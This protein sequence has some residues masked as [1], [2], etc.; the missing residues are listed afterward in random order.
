M[1]QDVEQSI[2]D[3]VW[4]DLVED[5][6]SHEEVRTWLTTPACGAVVCFAGVVRDHSMGHSGVTSI[7]Y[8]SY[9]QAVMPR[10]ARIVERAIVA[11]P[12]TERAAIVHRTGLVALGEGAVVVG[13]SAPH[14]GTAFDVARFCID[15]VKETLPIWKLENADEASGWALTGVEARTVDEASDDWLRRHRH[16][17]PVCCP[18]ETVHG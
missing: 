16:E 17:G 3:R 14:R 5:P 2:S 13:A 8:E 1:S 11:W 9:S 4:F 10:L 12:E 6:I 7:A 18:R 15:V